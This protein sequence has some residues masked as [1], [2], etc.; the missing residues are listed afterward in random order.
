MWKIVGIVGVVGACA[1]VIALRTREELKPREI[2]ARAIEAHGGLERL[3]KLKTS[4]IKTK[5][6]YY[7]FGVP[8]DYQGETTLDLPN[9]SRTEAESKIGN[10]LQ[11]I[12]GDSGWIKVGQMTREC[13]KEECNEMREQLNALRIAH[14]TVLTGDDYKLSPLPEDTVNER[15]ALG[16]RVQHKG[17]RDVDLYFDKQKGYLVKMQTRLKDPVRSGEEITAE[18]LYDDY[19]EINGVMV[20][21]KF[22]LMYDGKPHSEVEVA[23]VSFPDRLEEDTFDKP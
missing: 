9:H 4:V 18:T 22:T 17:Y 2:I 15:P 23:D 16:M 3:V 10:Y 14:L 20:A 19:K 12:N 21:H 13:G 1:L 5:G 8:V 7:G 6:Q 11:V